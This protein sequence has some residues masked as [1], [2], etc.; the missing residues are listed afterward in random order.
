MNN[1]MFGYKRNSHGETGIDNFAKIIINK[2]YSMYL[3]GL[4]LGKIVNQLK[5]ENIILPTGKDTWSRASIDKMLSNKLYVPNIISHELFQNVIN[6]R[7]KRSN[8]KLNNDGTIQRKSTRYNSD[9]VLSGLLVCEECGHNYRRITKSNREIVW[10]CA[11]KIEAKGYCIHSESVT[12]SEVLIHICNV[13]NID[14]FNSEIVKNKIEKIVIASD[15]KLK[16]YL[17]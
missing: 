16:F 11:S 17:K 5:Q 14:T 3:N 8:V 1:I 4:S 9:N 10:R 12:E 6:E 15:N 7:N 13:L 2:I